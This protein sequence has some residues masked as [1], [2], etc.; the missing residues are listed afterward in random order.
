[1]QGNRSRDT[2]PELVLRKALREAGLTG[3]RLDWKKAPGR[4]DI[5][6]PGKKLAV[7]VHGCFWHRCEQ[8]NLPT[9]K[10]NTDY[11]TAKFARNVARDKRHRYDLA[12]GGWTVLTFF[13]C[14][15]KADTASCVQQVADLL[16]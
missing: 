3:Y 4:P 12:E 10:S 13:E 6:Y 7:F 14:E 9:P 16:A 5:A 1:M 8:C 15:I 11:W 2:K